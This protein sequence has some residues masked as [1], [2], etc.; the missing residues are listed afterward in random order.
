MNIK[1]LGHS[2]FYVAGG[3][4]VVV[5]PF[6]DIGYGQE[7]VNADYCLISHDH[8]DHNAAENVPGAIVIDSDKKEKLGE[9]ISLRRIAT[10]HDNVGGRLRGMNA[11]HVFTIDGVT[12]CH[13]GDLGEN[14]SDSTAKKIGGC[15]VLFVPSKYLS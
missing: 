12:F 8:F 1:Y 10:F 5:D 11:V 9:K 15:D 14:Y 3:F 4:S 7:V 13:L 6:H 2:C